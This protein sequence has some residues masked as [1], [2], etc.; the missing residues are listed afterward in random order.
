MNNAQHLLVGAVLVTITLF[1][2]DER[3][4]CF[5]CTKGKRRL[6]F[7]AVAACRV[8]IAARCVGSVHG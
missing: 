4:S 1:S 8:A 2:T 5:C 3:D 6:L 7:Q